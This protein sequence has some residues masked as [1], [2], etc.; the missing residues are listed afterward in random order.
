[1]QYYFK[2]SIGT[3]NKIILCFKS[4]SE[5]GGDD[6]RAIEHVKG[7]VLVIC[8]P[9]NLFNGELPLLNFGFIKT[10]SMDL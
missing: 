5:S 6:N 10:I 3:Y 4:V 9:P 7:V 1:M 2:C 8:F